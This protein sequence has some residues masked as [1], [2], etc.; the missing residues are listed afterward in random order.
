[1]N[2]LINW[3]AI[4][5]LQHSNGPMKKVSKE[6]SAEM[7]GK[8]SSIYNFMAGLEEE[9]T[10]KQVE[11]LIL[12]SNDTVLDIGCGI[13]RL[14]VPIAKQVKKVTAVDIADKMLDLCK[15]NV[16]EAGLDNVDFDIVD[17]NS[18]EIGKDIEKHDVAFASRTVA[19][20][21]ILKLNSVAKKYAYVLSF[22]EYPSLRDIQLEMLEG[23]RG[24]QK[25]KV[26]K[27]KDRMF[28]Y[29]VTFNILYDLGIDPMVKVLED[30]FERIYET[31]EAAYQDL[32]Q[33][34]VEFGEDCVLTAEE[35]AT[36]KNNIDK[37]LSL[38][39]G[40]YKFSRKTKTYVIGWKPVELK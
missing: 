29:N 6:Q 21:D 19:L 16:E 28:G 30:G 26:D 27:V 12:D 18:V 5:K 10:L 13:G 7:W 14:T 11:T 22:A 33:V 35:E 39:N 17:W 24:V 36:F 34:T 32:K 38:E 2:S 4:Q 8:V 9:Y 1:M 15:K 20:T 31:K 23:I 40:K 25:R 37:Y 3:S